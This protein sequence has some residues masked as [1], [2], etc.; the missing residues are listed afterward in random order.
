MKARSTNKIMKQ[1]LSVQQRQAA[2]EWGLKEYQRLKDAH[3]AQ[4]ASQF[5]LTFS[6]ALMRTLEEYLGFGEKRRA[7]FQFEM[8]KRMDELCEFLSSNTYT[9]ESNP[10]E[11]TDFEFNQIKLEQFAKHYGIPYNPDILWKN[12]D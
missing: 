3:T 12:I 6:I 5:S 2:G 4:V 1:P 11:Q 9:D 10:N 7:S 8:K